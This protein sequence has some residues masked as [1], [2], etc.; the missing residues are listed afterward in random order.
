MKNK[1]C[2]NIKAYFEI[3]C[4]RICVNVCVRIWP[5]PPF[6][7]TQYKKDI[8]AC[9]SVKYLVPVSYSMVVIMLYGSNCILEIM[10]V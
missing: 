8:T 5:Y 3:V 1:C 9:Y 10:E 2:I 4:V 6:P 7:L